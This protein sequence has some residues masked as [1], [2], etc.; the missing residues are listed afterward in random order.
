MGTFHEDGF[1]EQQKLLLSYLSTMAIDVKGLWEVYFA[2]LAKLA[3]FFLSSF[4][5]R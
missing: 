3:C 1:S 5:W 4:F 2:A